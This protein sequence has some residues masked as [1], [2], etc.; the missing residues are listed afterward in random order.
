M[1]SRSFGSNHTP[2]WKQRGAGQAA[3]VEF[4]RSFRLQH[5]VV[6]VVLR[7]VKHRCRSVFS[8]RKSSTNNCRPTSIGT[9]VGRVFQVGNR[10][11][12]AGLRPLCACIAAATASA[13]GYRCRATRRRQ[14][15]VLLATRAAVSAHQHKTNAT[16]NSQ[17]RGSMIYQWDCKRTKWTLLDMAARQFSTVLQRRILQRGQA[18]FDILWVSC[19]SPLHSARF[20]PQGTPTMT[21]AMTTVVLTAAILAALPPVVCLAA[22]DTAKDARNIVTGYPIPKE[23]YCDQPYVVI[24]K[25]GNWLCLLT[26]GPGD[27]IAEVP[28]RGGHHQQGPGQDLV[29]PD[30]HRA[31]QRAGLADGLLGRSAYHA[32][33]PGLCLLRL[34]RRRREEDAQRASRSGPALGLVLLPLLGRQRP[35]LVQ[36]AIPPARSA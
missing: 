24:T 10:P 4:Q 21:Q 1:N 5:G 23:G 17:V 18:N 15:E 33:R 28:A 32:Q 27:R 25:D 26:T 11:R 19:Y 9:T 30:R 13:I 20:D 29:E 35:H 8:I 31:G 14:R 36:G 6:G 16:R 3:V 7:V 12:P 2:S 22:D 34:R